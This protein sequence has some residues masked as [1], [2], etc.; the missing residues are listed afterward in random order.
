MR[1]RTRGGS[2]ATVAIAL[3]LV[4]AAC[5]GGDDEPTPSAAEES[6][7]AAVEEAR[8]PGGRL[9]VAQ[10]LDFLSWG[11]VNINPS[12]EWFYNQMYDSVIR[13]DAA[14]VPEGR[15]AHSWEQSDDAREITLFLRDDVVFHDGTAFVAQHI[16]D[17]LEFIQGPTSASNLGVLAN[18][19]TDYEIRNDYELVLKS[20]DPYPH[21]LHFLDTMYIAKVQDLDSMETDPIGTGPFV[22]TRWTPGDS[23]LLTANE[24]YWDGRPNLDEVLIRVTPSAQAAVAALEAGDVH[25]YNL[26]PLTEVDRLSQVPGL[27]LEVLS[28]PSRLSHVMMKTDQPPFDDV[29]VRQAIYWALDRERM[30]QAHFGDPKWARCLPWNAS[31]PAHTDTITCEQ[32]LERSRELLRQAGYGEGEGLRTL[33]FVLSARPDTAAT[34]AP[35]LQEDLR[36]IGVVVTVEM[37]ANAEASPRLRNGAFEAFSHV[38]ARMNRDPVVMFDGARPMW[39]SGEQTGYSSDVYRYIAERAA[40]TRD[41]E[42]RRKIFMEFNAH[43]LGNVWTAPVMGNPTTAGSSDRVSGLAASLDGAI[44]LQNVTLAPN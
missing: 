27:N 23:A 31:S 25:A 18:R 11:G 21:V 7:P 30:A 22:R 17:T 6:A 43:L 16:V 20:E 19:I 42:E 37:L 34:I 29:R 26:V 33:E 41:P 8:A 39:P 4:L 38:L 9:I 36:R 15:L 40:T 24:D 32:D 10:S 1:L 12:G 3:S 2:I 44:Y 5:S 14:F 35:I 13:M 28:N